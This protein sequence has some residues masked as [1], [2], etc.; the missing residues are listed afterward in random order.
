MKY[1]SF[2]A[3]LVFCS[4]WSCKTPEP[5]VTIP[6]DMEMRT[7]DTIFV[8]PP[9]PNTN[10]GDDEIALED[11]SSFEL[12][13]FN[14][15]ATRIHNLL[16]TKLDIRFDW[17]KE[18]V[19]GKANLRLTPYF[20]P[21]DE[22]LLDAK[23]FI[24]NKISF[25]GGKEDLKYKYNGEQ[26]TI[27]LGKTYARK[28]TFEI[29]IDYVATPR[30]SGG[31][32]AITS[33]KGLFF[34][35]PK[36]KEEGKPQQIWTQG[37]TE[38]NSR[39]FPTIDKPNER[40]T[41]EI[42]ITVED[43]YRTLSN[44][45]L[46]SSTKNADGT[47]TDY[48]NMDLPH[49]PYLFAF[50]VGEYAVVQDRWENIPL[51]YYVEPNFKEWARDIFP[52]TPDMLSL[53][54]E[55]LGVRYPWQKYAQVIVRDYVSG[56]MENTTAVIFG[57]F[58]QLE[59][60]ALVDNLTNE[61]IVAHEMFHHWFGNYV[62]TESWANLTM[63]EGF[64]N[65]SEYLWL[66]HKYGRAEAD[67]HWLQEFRG[68]LA[69]KN[70]HPLIHY[71]YGEKEE[72]FDQHS[73]NKGGMVLH[74]LRDYIGDE[75]FWASLNL[76]LTRNAY[77]EVEADELRLACEDVTGKDL[78]WF[79]DQWFHKQGHPELSVLYDYDEENKKV[80]VT[81]EQQQ[82]AKKMPPIFQLPVA[83]HFY[84]SEKEFTRKEVFI[85]K[86]LQ[87][88]E[89]DM[90]TKPKLIIF[91][92]DRVL[93]AVI[94]QNKSL[95][96][97]AFQYYHGP[98]FM[99]RYE[100][101]M[102]LAQSDDDSFDQVFVDALNDPFYALR[103][104]G[105]YRMD[106]ENLLIQKKMQ[107][108]ALNDPHSEVRAS[109]LERL[110]EVEG[111]DYKSLFEQILKDDKS[112]VVKATAMQG[113][114]M[115]YVASGDLSYL[116]FFENNWLKIDGY[117]ALEFFDGYSELVS[118]GDVAQVL[119]SA[120]KMKQ[121]ATQDGSIFRR[122]GATKAI[123]NLHGVLYMRIEEAKNTNNY[124]SLKDADAILVDMIQEIKQKETNMQLKQIYLD[125]PNP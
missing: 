61:K 66:E 107:D 41:Q 99:D 81:V 104:F 49:A 64:A 35:N 117:E 106:M 76:Y 17:E 87:T 46:T 10:D 52:Y 120:Q 29:F 98:K 48:W 108:I 112:A 25:A 90:A 8:R 101:L 23:G 67:Y 93:L 62:T 16:H 68:Y 28:D 113:L 122:F 92:A 43:K 21:T 121:V 34:I 69:Q 3:L 60:D 11:A 42:Y 18:Q 63:N 47:R 96:E 1:F 36:G 20:Y 118:L 83:I 119:A 31:S 6:A 2:L 109:A 85:K 65:Y 84:S 94:N 14:P 100:A 79:F 53:F 72:M 44:G 19:I 40:C 13:P 115:G 33:D 4:T 50:V 95:E 103:T 58:M 32:A 26:I 27:Q 45:L 7:M 123:N 39:W 114:A 78:I 24:F 15:S 91:D 70:I 22:L 97:Y 86:R 75:A 74:M 5:L 51:E 88:F 55:K 82:D 105:V 37:E 89:F 71:G 54:S 57:E 110:L 9:L 59:R 56:A 111:Q 124:Q 38:H 12:K 125:I 102:A 77:T 73:Y 116:S 30:A 80:L